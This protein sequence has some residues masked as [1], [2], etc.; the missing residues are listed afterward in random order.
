[1]RNINLIL[2]VITILMVCG[3]TSLPLKQ[4]LKAGHFRIENFEIDKGKTNE[5]VYLACLQS[6]P[7][8]WVSGKQIPA[9]RYNFLIHAVVS[10]RGAHNSAKYGFVNIEADFEANKSYKI[11]DGAITVWVEE[12]ISKKVVSEYKHY[13]LESST[14]MGFNISKKQCQK[15]S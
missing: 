7:L 13:N 9:G 11:K 6:R 5:L 4:E 14:P 12:G 10:K 1:M 3:C 15:F 8:D 2:T